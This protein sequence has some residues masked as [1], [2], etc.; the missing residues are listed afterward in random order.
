MH[1]KIGD[2]FAVKEKLGSFCD[3]GEIAEVTELPDGMVA[4]AFVDGEKE[5]DTVLK[6]T[7]SMDIATFE[8]YFEKVEEE[9][10]EE[11]TTE[12]SEFP[13]VK[14]E[15]IYEILDQSEF[16]IYTTFDKCTVVSCHLPNGFVITESATCASSESYDEEEGFG[17]CYDKIF[18]RVWEL[19]TYRLQQEFYE[20]NG[21][22]Y[23]GELD[24]DNCD[25]Y[26]CS[27]NPHHYYS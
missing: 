25:N 13:F 15:E 22:P 14:E 4:F 16:D 19:E 20:E 10:I 23:D 12:E 27:E 26:D 7:G 8:K 9:A 11:E 2:K 24:C 6:R 18:N 5:G 17:I 3:V 1:I 21:Y